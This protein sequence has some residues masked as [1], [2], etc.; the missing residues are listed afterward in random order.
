MNTDAWFL[1]DQLNGMNA[2]MAIEGLMA[3][4][5]D[6]RLARFNIELGRQ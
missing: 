3:L 6:F 5:L 4:D 2:E 1:Y